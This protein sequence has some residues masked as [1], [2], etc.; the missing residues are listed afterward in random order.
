MQHMQ[1][2]M[3]SKG[4]IDLANLGMAALVFGQLVSGRTVDIGLVVLGIAFEVVFY[5]GAFSLSL[6]RNKKDNN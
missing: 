4:L 6:E 3:F 2:E 5:I 1:R